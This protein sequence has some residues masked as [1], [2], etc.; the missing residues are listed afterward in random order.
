[1]RKSYRAL[2]RNAASSIKH[3]E[4]KDVTAKVCS[5]WKLTE[6]QDILQGLSSLTIS[7]RGGDNGAVWMISMVF[8]YLDFISEPHVYFLEHL[9]Y[10]KHLSVAATHKGPP[11]IEGDI[12]N[13]ALPLLGHHTPYPQILALEYTFIS[14]ALAA[15]I[16]AHS[17][18]LESIRLDNC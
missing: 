4:L 13:T 16:T 1:M 18:T 11:V 9:S 12:S 7:F 17:N 5:A 15:F 6:F 2:S 14:D 8:G 3:L 10:V